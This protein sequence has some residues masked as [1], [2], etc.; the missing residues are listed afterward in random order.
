MRRSN[1]VTQSCA[2][3]LAGACILGA[4]QSQALCQVRGV[5]NLN[6]GNY[7][8]V[9][10]APLETTGSVVYRCMA[11]STPITIELG[12]GRS[13][14]PAARQMQGPATNTLAYNL[15]VD[16]T[17]LNIWGDGSAGTY[18]LGP[19]LPLLGLDVAIPIYGRIPAQ[20]SASQ[21]AYSDTL[22]VTLNL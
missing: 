16:P 22:V 2:L 19:F 13:N 20:Q 3:L 12:A 7:N 10:A 14:T 1:E 15:F 4:T 5:V 9:S 6:F 17:R 21:G 8:P 18:R 11:H